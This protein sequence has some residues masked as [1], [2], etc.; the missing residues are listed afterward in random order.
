[1]VSVT[2]NDSWRRFLEMGATMGEFTMARA[3]DIARGLTAENDEVR[4]RAWREVD[5]LARFGFRMGEQLFDVAKDRVTAEVRTRSTDTV[6][7]L[8]ERLGD[9]LAPDTGAGRVPDTKDTIPVASSERPAAGASVLDQPETEPGDPSAGGERPKLATQKHKNHARFGGDDQPGGS[10]KS[11][12]AKA[13]KHN[14]KKNKKKYKQNNMEKE[15]V[16]DSGPPP[17]RALALAKE[18]GSDASP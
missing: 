10:D 17:F 2:T 7:R 11:R 9:L 15:P 1:V 16:A 18:P 3:E 6:D 8:L 5:Q 4:E 14:K 13:S 12:T